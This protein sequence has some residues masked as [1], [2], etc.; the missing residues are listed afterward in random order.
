MLRAD[1]LARLG[2]APFDLC[3]I[4]GGITG[5]GIARDAAMR[6]LSVALLEADDYAAGTS[7]RSSRLIHGGVRYLEHGHLGL[8]FEASRERRTLLRIAPHLVR[9]LAFTWPVYRGAR[10]QLLTLGAGLTLYDALSLFRNVGNHK[11]LT[12]EAVRATEPALRHDGLAGG[13]RYWDAATNDTRLTLANI[14]AAEEHGAVCVNHCAVRHRVDTTGDGQAL[15]AHDAVAGRDVTVRARL[16]I[17][18]TGPWSDAVSAALGAGRGT[19]V[20]GSKGVHLTV[21]ADTVAHRGALTL[22]APHDGRVFFVLPAGAFTIIGTTETPTTGTADQ[23]R[24]TEADV[25]YLIEATHHFFPNS[26][27]TRDAVIA[28]WAGVR[29]LAAQRAQGDAASASR[30]HTIARTAPGVLSVTGGKLTTYRAM[31]ADVV[32]AACAAL[33]RRLPAAATASTPLPGGDVEELPVEIA[34]VV[35]AGL[36]PA[37][38][39]RLVH[40]YGSAWVRLEH[41][42]REDDALGD[43]IEPGLP[44]LLAEVVYAARQEQA[45][46]LADVLVRRTHVAFETRDHGRAAARRIA[47]VLG[48]VLGWDD[49]ACARAIAAYDADATRLFAIDP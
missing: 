44:Y 21:P 41:L 23:V 47:P 36:A 35:H 11:R 37:V 16:I 2:A 26:T 42:V 8:V 39:E 29:P 34:R 1:R 49:A 7:S 28:A 33:G 25:A 9:P 18:A 10:I 3:I 19:G 31:A 13:A 38:A 15:L 20:L 24:A 43:E 46:T 22:L 4:G 45:V 27:L 17:N 5:A 30:E 6:G 48:T 40:A 12:A 14:L 32:D